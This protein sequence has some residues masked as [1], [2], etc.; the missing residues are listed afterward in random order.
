[1]PTIAY[2]INAYPKV[3]H[4]FIR[5]EILALERQRLEIKRIAIRG[6]NEEPYDAIDGVEQEKTSYVLQGGLLAVGLAAVG[7]ALTH[8]IRF[9]KALAKAW[10]LSRSPAQGLALYLV[11]L[12]E[13]CL[14]ARWLKRDRIGHVHAHFG[15]NATTVALLA[16]IIAGTSY[17]FTVHGPEE[18]DKPYQLRLREKIE[19]A[20]F[21]VAITSFCRS[22]LFRFAGVEDWDKVRIVHCAID[23]RFA[24]SEGDHPLSTDTIVCVGRLCEQKG[25]IV[26]VQA[27]AKL[28]ERGVR[29]RLVL[30]GDGEMRG[31]IEAMVARLGLVGQV[32]F[33]GAL[34]PD[35][36]L[37]HLRQARAFVL[38]SFAEGL[39]VAIME[40][41][42]VRRPVISTTIAGIPELVRSGQDG[43]LVPP[44]DVGALADAIEQVLSADDGDI[45]AHGADSARRIR[46][47]HSSDAEATKLGGLFNEFARA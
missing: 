27:L 44:S 22:Q 4:S 7:T 10:R 20:A 36:V 5:T 32:E 6:W 30:V 31:A 38:P 45:L 47:R 34:G 19:A 15:T 14:V 39:P 23:P 40:A 16:G 41:M 3:S 9:L 35:Q 1:M 12:A 13:A 42:A 21:V 28:K 24:E 29:A 11:Y 2:L 33:T 46:E 37:T 26:L 8:P 18:F 17:S 43:L 25:Q